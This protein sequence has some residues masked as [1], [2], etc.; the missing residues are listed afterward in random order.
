MLISLEEKEGGGGIIV[1]TVSS[2]ESTL[3]EKPKT[4]VSPIFSVKK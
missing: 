1:I 2:Q 3:G 4:P